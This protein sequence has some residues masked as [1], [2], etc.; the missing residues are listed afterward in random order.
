M[1]ERLMLIL[2]TALF[3]IICGL[4]LFATV[5]AIKIHNRLMRECLIDGQP[6]YQCAGL[7]SGRSGR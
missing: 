1:I 4:S 3:F 7:R 6:E 2:I 5:D